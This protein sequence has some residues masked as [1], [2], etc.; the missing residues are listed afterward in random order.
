MTLNRPPSRQ[1]APTKISRNRFLHL[2]WCASLVQAK[3]L[4]ESYES[5]VPDICIGLYIDSLK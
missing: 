1:L 2:H 3:K 4:F 5:R